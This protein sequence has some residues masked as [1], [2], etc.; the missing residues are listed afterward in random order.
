MPMQFTAPGSGGLGQQMLQSSGAA[1]A[2]PGSAEVL[3]EVCTMTQPLNASLR[4]KYS[5][6]GYYFLQNKK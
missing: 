3:Q 6:G 2:F 1:A 4:K 5:I